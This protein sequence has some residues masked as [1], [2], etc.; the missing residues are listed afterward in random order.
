[1]NNRCTRK[2]VHSLSI[3]I[4]VMIMSELATSLWWRLFEFHNA[5][6]NCLQFC[7]LEF[8]DESW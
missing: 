1:M 3:Y 2:I 6:W 7:Y 5:F 4:S 8:F